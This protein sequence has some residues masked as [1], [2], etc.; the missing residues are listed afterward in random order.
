MGQ[1]WKERGGYYKG[2]LW[3][4]G[5]RCGT[6]VKLDVVR[7]KS[8]PASREKV[9]RLKKRPPGWEI[10]KAVSVL[11]GKNGPTRRERGERG[12]SAVGESC[13]YIKYQCIQNGN[14]SQERL[15]LIKTS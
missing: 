8:K 10:G 6:R 12:E 15:S 14:G 7:E 11:P 5:D 3:V 2:Y 13:H 9:C 1:A 4:V